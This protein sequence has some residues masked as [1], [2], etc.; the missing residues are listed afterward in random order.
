MGIDL[1]KKVGSHLPISFKEKL[2]KYRAIDSLYHGGIKSFLNKPKSDLFRGT[3]RKDY[4]RK[5]DV[6]KD[7][8]DY[9][10]QELRAFRGKLYISGYA[11][12]ESL[13]IKYVLVEFNYQVQKY[14]FI[15]KKNRCDENKISRGFQNSYFEIESVIPLSQSNA[16][17]SIW[18][19]LSNGSAFFLERPCDDIALRDSYHRIFSNFLKEINSWD[20]GDILEVGSRARS[21]VTRKELISDK[22]KYVGLD[23]KE[24]ENVD[25]IA[26]AHSLSKVF[27]KKQFDAIFSIATFEHLIM[28]WVVVNEMNKVLNPGGLVFICTHQTF[29]L[30][31][32]PWDFWRYSTH[33]WHGLFNYYTGFEI[34]DAEMGES[35]ILVPQNLTNITWKIENSQGFLGSAVIAK[36]NRDTSLRW[37]VDVSHLL[38]TIYPA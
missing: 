13:T 7:N 9:F 3:Y 27:K 24:G 21:G 1:I 23:I 5:F 16:D 4:V 17:I 12:H 37:D 29:P 32:E 36:K 26:D 30:H 31:D 19:Q 11:R 38:D 10:I 35:T 34:V 8:F 20:H 28:P 6:V 22:L 15:P 14:K 18:F 25:V 2:K 33:T